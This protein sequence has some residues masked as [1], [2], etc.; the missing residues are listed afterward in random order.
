[1]NVNEWKQ[2]VNE[3][4]QMWMHEYKCECMKKYVNEWKLVNGW[5]QM[6]INEK[7]MWMNENIYH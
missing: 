1:M 3:W 2:N 5:K 4:K 7:Q 6:W